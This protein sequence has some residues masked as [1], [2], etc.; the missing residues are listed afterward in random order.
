MVEK[1]I[2]IDSRAS[3]YNQENSIFKIQKWINLY[4]QFE[5]AEARA[6]VA[7]IKLKIAPKTKRNLGNRF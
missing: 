4:F 3:F 1:N 5:S 7:H 2:V 6:T